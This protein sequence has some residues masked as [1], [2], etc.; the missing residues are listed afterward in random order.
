[1][2]PIG[3]EVALFDLGKGIMEIDMN[4]LALLDEYFKKYTE[5]LNH[6]IPDGII[7]VDLFLLTEFDLLDS[8]FEEKNPAALTRYFHVV[9]SQ[10]KITLINEHFVVWIIPEKFENTTKTLTLIALN[11]PESLTLELG[12]LASGVYNTSRLVLRILEKFLH[13]IQENEDF[14]KAIQETDTPPSSEAT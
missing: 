4:K 14:I 5:N 2:L 1:M 9:E 7:P 6:W 13:E 10:D 12:F 11:Y 3:T 8:F